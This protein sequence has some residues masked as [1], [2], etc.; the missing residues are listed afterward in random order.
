VTV[1]VTGATG[2]VGSAVVRAL[3]ARGESVRM[4]VRCASDR[5]NLDGLCAEPVEGDLT[6]AGSLDAAVRDCRAVFHV[7]ADYRLW[8]PDP[9]PIY[10][11]NVEG[12][13]QLLAA[14]RRAGVERVVYTSSVATLGLPNHG[15]GT[16]GDEASPVTLADMIGHY[17]RSKF[18]AEEVAREFARDGLWVTIVNPSAPIGPRD[19]KPTPTGK[20]VLDAAAGRMPAYV[21]TG[22]NVVHVDDVAHG[23]LL[24]WERGRPGERYILGGTDMTLREILVRIAKIVGGKPPWLRLPHAAVLPVAYAAEAFA[25]LTGGSTG[26]TVDGVRLARKKMFFSTHK[27]Q[28]E[29]GYSPRPAEEALIDA[30]RWYRENGYLAPA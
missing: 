30:V 21:D 7:A 14:A 1:L 2:F 28:T 4:L 24:A 25:R 15:D 22:L 11:T 13:R 18:L 19:R 29:L 10:A 9:T 26:I 16:P 5:R 6:D 3:E 8:A 27:A 12:T 20:M 23:H 17:K